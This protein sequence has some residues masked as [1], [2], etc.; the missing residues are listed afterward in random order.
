MAQVKQRARKIKE[1]RQRRETEEA[2]SKLQDKDGAVREEKKELLSEAQEV[3][4]TNI[5]KRRSQRSELFVKTTEKKNKLNEKENKDK[6]LED[7][8]GDVKNS[9]RRRREVGGSS[10]S[11]EVKYLIT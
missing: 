10:S 9:K 4:G 11:R 6:L 2:N 7:E 3:A 8:G 1:G 5:V